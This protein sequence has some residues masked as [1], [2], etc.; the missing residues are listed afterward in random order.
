MLR[1]PVLGIA[2]GQRLL[3]WLDVVDAVGFIEEIA[4]A[5]AVGVYKL[6]HRLAQIAFAERGELKTHVLERKLRML[7][8]IDCG[9]SRSKSALL[10]DRL[11]SALLLQRKPAP[12]EELLRLTCGLILRLVWLSNLPSASLLAPFLCG[13]S[14]P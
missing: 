14:G 2:A 6:Q 10:G 7:C 8:V 12:V 13:A 1:F 4:R 11:Q 3:G 5:A 9:I